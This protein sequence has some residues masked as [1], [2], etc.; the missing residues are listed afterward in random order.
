MP[1]ES[2]GM[3][4]FQTGANKKWTWLLMW[5]SDMKLTAFGLLRMCVSSISKI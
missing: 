4:S 1:R 2:L 5:G 3:V